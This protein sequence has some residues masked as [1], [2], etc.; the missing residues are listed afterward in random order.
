MSEVRL[1]DVRGPMS[2]VRGP[3]EG[4]PPSRRLLSLPAVAGEGFRSRPVETLSLPTLFL[5]SNSVNKPVA[6]VRCFITKCAQNHAP[7]MPCT[8]GL[9]RRYRRA[10]MHPRG[11]TPQHGVQSRMVA[12]AG[13]PAGQVLRRTDRAFRVANR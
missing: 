7:L 13:P 12:D 9:V 5:Y 6:S 11:P 8:I 2:E 3:K 4:K 10:T 1:P